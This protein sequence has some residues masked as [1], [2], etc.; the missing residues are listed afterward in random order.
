MSRRLVARTACLIALSLAI[1]SPVLAQ[2]QGA[3]IVGTIFDPQHAGIPGATVTVTNIATNVARTASTDREGN[4]VVTPLDPGIYKVTAAVSGFQTTVREGIELTVGQAARVELTLAISSL[5]TE[6]LVT[7]QTPLLNTESA[8]LSQ[9]ISNE[10]IVDLPLNGRSFHELARL[11]PGVALLAP[12]GNSQ[13]VRPE[14]V[15]GNIMGGVSGRQT[16]FLLDG[17]D[18]T[19]EH[20]G[21]TWIQ[22]SVDALQE[23]SVQQ[24]A[25]SAEFH[26]AGGTFN[27]VTKS[28]TNRV[29]GSAFE[30][31]RNDAFDAKNFFA[32]TKEKLER[33][34]FGGT[35]GGPVVIP[36][37]VDG[38]DRT[39]FFASYEGQRRKSGAVDVAIVP[40]PA[41]RQGN[42][43]GLAPI[44]DPLTTVGTHADGVCGQHHPAAADRTGR[45]VLPAIHPAAERSEQHLGQQP[46]RRV[47]PGPGHPAHGP[48]TG[49]AA[50]AVRAIQP[51]FQPRGPAEHVSGAG[52]DRVVG[53]GLQP[54][55]RR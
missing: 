12:S 6:V 23:F 46:D 43:Q 49:R 24:N 30:F 31:L 33:N 20:Q 28:G 55:R 26:G 18:I 50:Q 36:G 44:Y 54:R 14:I 41:Q 13:L 7:T 29:R 11:T 48:F 22:T 5:A 39:F 51:P 9:V 37:L 34:Q 3:R 25:Y 40:S 8:T 32:Q 52:S 21:G 1:A 27:V 4:Y 35:F 16:R 45:A 42:F 17:V 10:Q 19:E 47:Q 38:R 15:N 2:L 53:T